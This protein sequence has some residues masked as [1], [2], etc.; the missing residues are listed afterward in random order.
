MI[1]VLELAEYDFKITMIS[2]FNKIK[3]YIKRLKFSP[4]NCKSKKNPMETQKWKVKIKN[5]LVDFNLRLAKEDTKGDK[6]RKV[7]ES[8]RKQDLPKYMNID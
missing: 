3:K 2:M 1:R 6:K 4:K 7:A 5:S 8:N